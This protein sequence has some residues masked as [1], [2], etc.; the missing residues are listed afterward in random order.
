M[1]LAIIVTT[2]PHLGHWG[3]HSYI[4]ATSAFMREVELISILRACIFQTGQYLVV[5]I[6]EQAAQVRVQSVAEPI[7]QPC[8]TYYLSE[9][10]VLS[11]NRG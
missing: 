9:K 5:T 1:C 10:N 11:P 8:Y 6:H 3:V 7:A 4:Q 2:P